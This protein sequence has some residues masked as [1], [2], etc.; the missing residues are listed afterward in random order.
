MHKIRR[1]QSSFEEWRS[2]EKKVLHYCKVRPPPSVVGEGNS[3]PLQWL[4]TR[5]LRRVNLSP[6]NLP[7]LVVLRTL[8]RL[9]STGNHFCSFAKKSSTIPPPHGNVSCLQRQVQDCVA[10]AALL[11]CNFPMQVI[12]IQRSRRRIQVVSPRTVL[13]ATTGNCHEGESF[14]PSS[15]SSRGE[16][17]VEKS[18]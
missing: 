16:I 6:R 11:H 8:F 15:S 5:T 13:L 14:L 2:T 18:L 12:C 1:L 10:S 3:F 7:L 9:L 4:A 17:R